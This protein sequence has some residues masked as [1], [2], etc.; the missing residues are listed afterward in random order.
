MCFHKEMFNSLVS[1]EEVIVKMVV[2]STC[3]VIN[4]RIVNV[5]CKDGLVCALEVIWYISEAQYLISIG[6]LD[7]E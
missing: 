6:V 4:T 2:D 5:T 7:E 1:K 3:K